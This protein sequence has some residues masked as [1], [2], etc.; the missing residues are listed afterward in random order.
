MERRRGSFASR[1]KDSWVNHSQ[2]TAGFLL[3][4]VAG[5]LA[6]GGLVAVYY[7]LSASY[8]G[9]GK[10][11]ELELNLPYAEYLAYVATA[12]PTLLQMAYY[13]S[14]VADHEIS[15]HAGVQVAHW[16]MWC[17]DTFLDVYQMNMG[18]SRS[19]L[20]SSVTAVILFGFVSEFL[21][22]F[23][24]SV[25]IGTLWSKISSPEMWSP[26]ANHRGSPSH[27][28]SQPSHGRPQSARGGRESTRRPARGG[29][30][31][32]RSRRKPT[33]RPT[34]SGEGR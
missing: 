3:M 15:R 6:A 13:Y 30:E 1:L 29:R 18:T 11:V 20:V 16:S 12:L 31:S 4:V 17:L 5:L 25:F 9:W 23:F 33:G 27:Q 22:T 32:T 24:G 28:G 26:S 21:I 19:L 34:L 10:L 7:D 8:F 14:L 2:S